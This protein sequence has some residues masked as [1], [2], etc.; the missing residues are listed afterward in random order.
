LF[1]RCTRLN[2]QKSDLDT[3]VQERLNEQK[4]SLDEAVQGRL[5]E[6]KAWRASAR[7]NWIGGLRIGGRIACHCGKRPV[8]SRRG[9]A[10]G[11]DLPT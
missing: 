7:A 11:E 2:K 5:D 8:T 4:S 3:A 9:W 1:K 10:P 6:Q